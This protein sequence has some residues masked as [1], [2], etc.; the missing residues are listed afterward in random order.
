MGGINQLVSFF[1]VLAPPKILNRIPYGRTIRVP[2]DQT[3]TGFLLGTEQMQV[4]AQAP[5]VP[6]LSFL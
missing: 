1:K 2:E 5:V 4:L 3:R 6:F